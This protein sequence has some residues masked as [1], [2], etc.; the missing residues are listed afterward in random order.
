MLSTPLWH[1]YQMRRSY[2]SPEYL[3]TTGGVLGDGKPA[4]IW[5]AGWGFTLLLAQPMWMKGTTRT[6]ESVKKFLDRLVTPSCNS[7]WRVVTTLLLFRSNT[8]VIE[9]FSP[10]PYQQKGRPGFS[11]LYLSS[12]TSR[13]SFAPSFILLM[14]KYW[15]EIQAP[16]FFPHWIRHRSV[17]GIFPLP[18]TELAC[19]W[20][21]PGA[22][23][24]PSS[25]SASLC[26]HLTRNPSVPIERLPN[27]RLWRKILSIYLGWTYL[28][29]ENPGWPVSLEVVLPPAPSCEPFLR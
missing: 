2:F 13:H 29:W 21:C 6:C 14:V 7:L 27:G 19:H 24:L 5:L 17:G 9:N 20:W 22:W 1:R 11:I 25:L 18:H 23:S 26:S 8:W 12:S 15:A 28:V 10:Q 4:L 16:V 3:Y